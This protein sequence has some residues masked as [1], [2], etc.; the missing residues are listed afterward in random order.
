MCI[1]ISLIHALRIQ[2]ITYEIWYLPELAF[3][4]FISY[5]IVMLDDKEERLKCFCRFVYPPLW[6]WYV[7]FTENDREFLLCLAGVFFVNETFFDMKHVLWVASHVLRTISDVAKHGRTFFD[8]KHVLWVASHVLR[9]ISVVAKQLSDQCLA[10]FD[11]PEIPKQDLTGF[12]G[13]ENNEQ[14]LASEIASAE[15][16]QISTNKVVEGDDEAEIDPDVFNRSDSGQS[17]QSWDPE[18]LAFS[19]KSLSEKSFDPDNSE[20]CLAG[21]DQ[22]LAGVENNE[23]D[24]ESEI[25]EEIRHIIDGVCSRLMME[26]DEKEANKVVEEEQVK[27]EAIASCL[28][29]LIERVTEKCV[30]EAESDEKKVKQA[31]ARS[32]WILILCQELESSG[33]YFQT[34]YHAEMDCLCEVE[35]IYPTYKQCID[36]EALKAT[37]RTLDCDGIHTSTS[38]KVDMRELT[39]KEQFRPGNRGAQI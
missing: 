6:L 23:Q 12:T 22:C 24:L 37:I 18:E 31:E 11:N 28:Q 33:A 34:V 36:K 1:V 5:R 21:F 38:F 2:A 19:D 9:T 15:V 26:Q 29:D 16:I 27:E 8:M 30:R 14:D 32:E 35:S 39:P 20:Q 13:F 4:L 17:S 25:A 7:T 3:L 10:R